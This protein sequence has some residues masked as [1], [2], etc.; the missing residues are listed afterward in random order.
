[1]FHMRQAKHV[2]TFLQEDRPLVM[3]GEQ[4]S[5]FVVGLDFDIFNPGVCK[6][7]EKMED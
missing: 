3:R 1:M 5:E 6:E 2:D 7:K 4:H